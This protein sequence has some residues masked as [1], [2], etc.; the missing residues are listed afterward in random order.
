MLIFGYLC[1]QILVLIINQTNKMKKLFTLL[2]VAGAL[3]I[4]S[5]GPSQADKD[6]AEAMVK[7]QMDSLAAVAAA[8]MTPT[9]P[10]SIAAKPD[11]VAAT[12]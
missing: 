2:F 10:D 5:C 7:A 1:A 11:S 4:I 6:K 9:M 8:S 3:S 12:K